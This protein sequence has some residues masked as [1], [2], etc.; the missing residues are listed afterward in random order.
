M[1]SEKTISKNIHKLPPGSLLIYDLKN[2]KNQ[3]KKYYSIKS[4]KKLKSCLDELVLDFKDLL[5]DSIKIRMRSDVEVATYLSGGL[6]SSLI[7]AIASNFTSKKLKTYSLV[8]DEEI[9]NKSSDEYYSDLVSKQYN[10][11]HTK[12][13]LTPSY[14]IE[15]LPKIIKQFGQPNCAVFSNWFLSKKI[16]ED[17]KV[18]L[19]GDG[20]D[21]LF[22]SYFLHRIAAANDEVKSSKNFDYLKNLNDYETKFFHDTQ[23]DLSKMIDY[24]TIFN[25][26]ERE[27][28][29]KKKETNS[30]INQILSQKIST[31]QSKKSLDKILEFDCNNLLVDQI[32]NYTDL[33]SMAH[34]LEVRVPFLDVRLVEYAFSLPSDYKIKD[35]ITKYFLKLVAESY[36]SSD[37]IY[38]PKE[39][40]VEPNI[41]WLK[42][43]LEE[44]ARD[45]I[46]SSSFDKHDLLNK[47]YINDLVNNF[48][49]NGDFYV[50]KRVWCLLMYGVYESISD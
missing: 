38:R 28:L 17:V 34:S 45:V 11:Y 19:S 29:F 23:D 25:F 50:G 14:F 1:P 32:L 30:I 16:S 7:T 4:K 44:Y 33:L 21:E 43:N 6:D 8:Y 35:G 26:E 27:K 49:L 3:V 31:L 36:L 41:H 46:L 12:V 37:L 18:A 10:T 15:E 5:I 9:N 39:G 20:A 13:L 42:Q 48:F 40:F 2:K 22:G 24:F 47:I